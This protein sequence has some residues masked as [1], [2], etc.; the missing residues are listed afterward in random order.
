MPTDNAKNAGNSG[1]QR[2]AAGDNHHK[3]AYYE[4]M[5]PTKPQPVVEPKVVSASPDSPN[6][7]SPA[8]C[9]ERIVSTPGTCGGKP[10][11]AGH[12]IKVADVAVWYERMGLSPDEIVSTWPSLTSR[13]STWPWLTITTTAT[14]LTRTSRQARSLSRSTGPVNRRSST[15][16]G[17]GGSMPRTIR[18]HLD[19]N[20]PR[21]VATGLRRRGIDV[22]SG[23]CMTTRIWQTELNTS[24]PRGLSPNRLDWTAYTPR[25]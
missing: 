1:E 20:C 25:R 3:S 22:T 13:M 18:F 16:S 8:G 15:R 19:E 21:A 9:E 2:Q 11:I 23:R 12:R 7:A 17:N 5:I 10:R 6:S 14:K 4:A 24:D